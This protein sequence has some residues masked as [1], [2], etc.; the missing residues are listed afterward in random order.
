V[1]I[2]SKDSATPRM[3][4]IPS[5][6]GCCSELFANAIIGSWLHLEGLSS[7][8]RSRVAVWWAQLEV[9]KVAWPAWK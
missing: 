7:A 9:S 5:D 3:S 4:Q 6:P 2:N 1:S 8:M